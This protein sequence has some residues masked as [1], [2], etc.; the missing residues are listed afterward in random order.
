VDADVRP[1]AAAGAEADALKSG[2]TA[3]PTG[4]EPLPRRLV[5]ST[6]NARRW[7]NFKANRRGFWSWWIFLVLFVVTLFANFIA[8]D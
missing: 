1:K 2:T 3:I 5:L 6:P 4:V 8:N 7:A